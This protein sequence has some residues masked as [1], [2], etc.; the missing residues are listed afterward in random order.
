MTDFSTES[1]EKQLENR[2]FWLGLRRKSEESVN[3]K[4]VEMLTDYGLM[5]AARHLRHLSP[6]KMIDIVLYWRFIPFTLDE[7]YNLNIITHNA[8]H[9]TAFQKHDL[10]R[11]WNSMFP[12]LIETRCFYVFESGISKRF[13]F[14]LVQCFFQRG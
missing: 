10:M 3:D 6:V 14:L 7:T 13:L 5:G 2:K 4:L 9:R 11:V 1:D 8:I 12:N